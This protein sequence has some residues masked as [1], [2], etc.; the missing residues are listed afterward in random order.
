[1]S[2]D[3]IETT[4]PRNKAG[5]PG[6]SDED[7]TGF[8]WLVLQHDDL[9]RSH[10]EVRKKLDIRRGIYNVS[11][12]LARKA[13]RYTKWIWLPNEAA[14]FVRSAVFPALALGVWLV[15]DGK[16]LPAAVVILAAPALLI[17]SFWLKGL[18]MRKLYDLASDI[19]E[20]QRPTYSSPAPC[21]GVRLFLW[22]DDVVAWVR[23]SPLAE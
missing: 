5:A 21:H 10:D 2:E 19:V 23:T 6:E 22:G 12:A 20:K 16:R 13:E 4:I 18:H 1:V 8:K 15:M 14:K 7:I 9:T 11:S 17:L 3:A